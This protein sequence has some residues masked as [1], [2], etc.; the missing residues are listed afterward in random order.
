ML[1]EQQPQRGERTWAASDRFPCTA[2][3]SEHSP[4]VAKLGEVPEGTPCLHKHM[5]PACLAVLVPSPK[6]PSSLPFQDSL[7]TW[8]EGGKWSLMFPRQERIL[9]K[10]NN[11]DLSKSLE[12]LI[13]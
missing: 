4:P 1:E 7:G 8:L 6:P 10:I 3:S 13:T 11:K 12:D 9:K 5:T 2:P